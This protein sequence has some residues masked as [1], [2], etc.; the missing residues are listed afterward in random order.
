MAL[1]NDVAKDNMI[2][3]Y[4]LLRKM[5]ES[6]ST[7]QN[8]LY[9]PQKICSHN[10]FLKQ[11]FIAKGLREF[12]LMQTLNVAA[13]DIDGHLGN[14]LMQL[15]EEGKVDGIVTFDHE[16]S[17]MGAEEDERIYN[18]FV[19]FL[20]V[21]GEAG[22]EDVVTALKTNETVASVIT[23]TEL[24][25]TIGNA[26]ITETARDIKETIGYGISDWYVDALRE[27]FDNMAEELIR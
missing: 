9:L 3:G 18:D 26:R 25:E 20:D 21:R 10:E 19:C 22:R 7:V 11:F 2:Y 24:A 5:R 23:T 14:F 16:H 1:S 17:A 6:G 4:E 13:Y 12:V 27:S 15:N 8:P